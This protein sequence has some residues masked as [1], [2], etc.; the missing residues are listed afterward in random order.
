MNLIHTALVLRNTEDSQ[1]KKQRLITE[2][3]PVTL[4][5]IKKV[6]NKGTVIDRILS[7]INMVTMETVRNIIAMETAGDIAGHQV[8]ASE[9]IG[10][11]E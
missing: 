7:M 10:E 4:G 8:E 3:S 2:T 6:K 5:N 1:V 11:I 9:M